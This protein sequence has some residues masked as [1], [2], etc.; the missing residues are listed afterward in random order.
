MWI[1]GHTVVQVNEFGGSCVALHK[2]ISQKD[3]AALAVSLRPGAQQ[4]VQAAGV[5][6]LG[7]N[8]Q[9]IVTARSLRIHVRA[10]HQQVCHTLHVLGRPMYT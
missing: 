1:A 2:D 9:R 10:V 5:A 3:G 4:R 6:M 8:V 7:C